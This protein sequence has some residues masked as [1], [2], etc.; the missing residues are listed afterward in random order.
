M[1][2]R[3]LETCQAVVLIKKKKKTKIKQNMLISDIKSE[4]QISNLTQNVI[5]LNVGT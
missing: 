4:V 1:G 2:I 3:L 5:P